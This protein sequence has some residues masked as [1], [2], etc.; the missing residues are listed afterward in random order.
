M[1]VL[2]T[3]EHPFPMEVSYSI[4]YQ[5]THFWRC[6]YTS[7]T[8]ESLHY[9]IVIPNTIKTVTVK[10][11][12]IE[13]LGVKLIGLYRTEDEKNPFFEVAVAYETVTREINGS[14]WLYNIVDLMG[15]IVIHKHECTLESGIY[16]DV[17]TKKSFGDEV[18]ISRFKV[19][20]D[21]DEE[22]G[23]ANLFLVKATC[24]EKDYVTLHEDML[25]SIS[26]LTITQGNEWKLA[27]ILKSVNTEK[28]A[29]LYFYYPGSWEIRKIDISL[30][31]LSHYALS[32]EI[33]QTIKVM[34]N[35]FFI[36]LDENA[37]AQFVFDT[38]FQRMRKTLSVSVPILVKC[39]NNFNKQLDQLWHGTTP[40]LS[41]DNLSHAILS[42]YVGKSGPV[43][44]Y[45]E[46]IAPLKEDSFSDW[47]I[48]KRAQEI[49][50]NSVNNSALL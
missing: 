2:N 33:E 50:I 25:Q 5:K 3:K 30:H 35:L 14:D 9:K 28:P 37:N 26:W 43:W 32:R 10:P 38:L 8:N 11:Q 20:K 7:T 48:N 18:M 44:F 42:A 13:G 1:D 24:H 36:V 21:H 40:V 4:E 41:D 34:M 47:A 46:S 29:K 45:A 23:S 6:I 22:S 17:L 49:I 27:E 15:E 12:E 39:D 19:I 16:A 31:S